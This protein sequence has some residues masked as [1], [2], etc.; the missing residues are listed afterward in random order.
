MIPATEVVVDEGGLVI[1]FLLGLVIFVCAYLAARSTGHSILIALG[2]I[3]G[4]LVFVVFG[5][6]FVG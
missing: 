6:D 4:V 5:F 3:V 2:A 1:G